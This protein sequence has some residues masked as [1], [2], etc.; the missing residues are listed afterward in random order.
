ML[1]QG[2]VPV[3]EKYADAAVADE[4]DDL[5]M[6]CLYVLIHQQISRPQN[7]L[8]RFQNLCIIVTLSSCNLV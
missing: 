3:W 4:E 1:V 7:A 6:L 5:A 8:L 2:L